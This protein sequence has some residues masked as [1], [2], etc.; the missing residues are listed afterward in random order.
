M[1][2]LFWGHLPVICRTIIRKKREIL[3]MTEMMPLSDRLRLVANVSD[4]M[5]AGSIQAYR[6]DTMHE[7]ASVIHDYRMAA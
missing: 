5:L 4:L 3:Q 1:C 7:S 6:P 2:V